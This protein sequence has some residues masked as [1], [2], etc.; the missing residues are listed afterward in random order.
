MA[1]NAKLFFFQKKA[2]SRLHSSCLFRYI[3]HAFDKGCGTPPP[4]PRF[5]R[6]RA[7]DVGQ[8][9]SGELVAVLLPKILMKKLASETCWKRPD[10]DRAALPC[11]HI[12]FQLHLLNESV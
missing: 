4:D 5:A 12:G 7:A 9:L 3:G 8:W 11:A 6:R 2:A 10:L 1:E